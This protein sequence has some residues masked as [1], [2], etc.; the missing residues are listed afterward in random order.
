[1]SKEAN[2]LPRRIV[3]IDNVQLG[4]ETYGNRS[5]FLAWNTV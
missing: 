5:F 3:D 4:I 2:R 1:M